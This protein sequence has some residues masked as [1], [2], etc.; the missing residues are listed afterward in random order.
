MTDY[1]KYWKKGRVED[2][3]QGSSAYSAA[4]D[5]PARQSMEEVSTWE[6]Q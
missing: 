2:K 3:R 6:L 5:C 4:D 1:R